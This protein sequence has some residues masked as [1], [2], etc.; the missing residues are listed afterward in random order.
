MISGM[1]KILKKINKKEISMKEISVKSYNEIKEKSVKG[2]VATISSQLFRTIIQIIGTAILGRLLRP[3]DFGLVAMVLTITN[4]ALMLSDLSL[5][6]ATIQ[7]EHISHAQISTLFWIN[8]A[9]GLFITILIIAT[10]PFIVF[11]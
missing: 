6:A 4:F 8:C 7:K 5:S 2:G 11:L 1:N 3:E 9:V 10:S